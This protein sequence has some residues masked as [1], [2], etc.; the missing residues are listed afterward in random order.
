[1]SEYDKQARN[2]LR[3]CDATMEIKLVERNAIHWDDGYTHNKYK[4]I[5]TTPFGIMEDFF[6][7]SYHNTINGINGA[8][9]YAILS[10]LE[11]YDVGTIDD[12][13]KE[14]G[15]EVNSWSDV[16]RIENI[17]SAV[18]KQYNKLCEIFTPE[19]MKQLREI[20]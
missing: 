18:V 14:F 11:K 1:M 5:I 19:Q 6:Y 9:E 2:F 16:R 4:F 10:C 13:V 17:Y 12:F 8:T 3:E 15:Y 7:D 20:W